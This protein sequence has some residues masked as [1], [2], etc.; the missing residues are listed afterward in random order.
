ME[1][2]YSFIP[3]AIISYG[4]ASYFMYKY[5]KMKLDNDEVVAIKNKR[6]FLYNKHQEIAAAYD[7]MI[8]RR[9]GVNKIIRFRR[10]L[11][12]YATG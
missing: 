5:S 8:E 1:F 10:T 7:K 11:I 6:E 3:I 9:E 2:N 4:S 12:S